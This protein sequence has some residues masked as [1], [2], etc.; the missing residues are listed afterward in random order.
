MGGYALAAVGT[1]QAQPPA[2]LPWPARLQMDFDVTGQARGLPYR[3]SS[4]LAWQSQDGRYEAQL[5]MRARF[6]GSR[7][8]TST[9]RWQD[10]QLMPER[11]VDQA[12][13]ERRFQLDWARQRFEFWREGQLVRE[14]PL[15]RGTQDRLSVFFALAW[16]AQRRLSTPTADAGDPWQVRVINQEG[17]EIWSFADR[18]AERLDTPAGTLDTRQLDRLPGDHN[19]TGMTLWLSRSHGWLPARIRLTDP[20]GDV[21]DQRLRLAS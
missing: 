16:Q 21:V 7:N 6:V 5:E 14:G 18:G 12:R 4:R 19:N 10:E 15:D 11:Y 8:Q 17:A 3:A 2:A 20:N 13:V 1:A 9:G